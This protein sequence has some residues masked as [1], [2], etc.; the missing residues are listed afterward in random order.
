MGM[1]IY[2]FMY[3]KDFGLCI[4]DYFKLTGMPSLIPRY[5]LGNWWCRDKVYTSEE[6][7]E[8]CNNFERNNIPL[9][10]FL[11]DKD[12]HIRNVD[13]YKDLET[14]YTLNRN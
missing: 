7:L 6:V 2:L 12:W 11:F 14:G 1:D 9:S 4:M 13:N 5:A 3:N 8:L 10:V